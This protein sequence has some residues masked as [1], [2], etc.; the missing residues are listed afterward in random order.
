MPNNSVSAAMFTA[1]TATKGVIV[2]LES[3]SKRSVLKEKYADYA[4]EAVS[5]VF[6]RC[7]FWWLNPLLGKGFK[8]TLSLD[9]LPSIDPEL[10]SNFQLISTARY[11]HM[12]YRVITL[13]RGN[14]IPLVY[15]KTLSL[16]MDAVADSAAVTMMSTDVE[17]ISSGLIYIHDT[18]GSIIEIILCLSLLW[19]EL[20]VATITPIVITSICTLVA[21][22]IAGAAAPRQKAWIEAIQIRVAATA[23]MLGSIKGVKMSG[24]TSRLLSNILGL[25]TAEINAS[26]K[27]RELLII[28]LGLA[29]TGNAMSPPIAFGIFV[30][31]D[32]HRGSGTLDTVTAFTALTLFALLSSPLSTLVESGTNTMAAIG[33]IER[34]R[35]YLVIEN[36]EE[37]RRPPPLNMADPETEEGGIAM[38]SLPSQDTISQRPNNRKAMVCV[39]GGSS[40]WA[41]GQDTVICDL[42]FQIYDSDLVMI[43][44]PVG[45]GKSTLLHTM[46]GEITYFDGSLETSFSRAAFCGQTPW[47]TNGTVQENIL[48]ISKFDKPWYDTVVRACAL[49]QDLYHFPLGDQTQV[50][51]NGMT[52]SGGQKQRL[53]LARAL[54]SRAN[55]VIVD[56]I[57]SGLDA[58]TGE[59]VFSEVFGPNGLFRRA[60]TTVIFATNLVDQLVYADHIIALGNDGRLV[61]QGTFEELNTTNGYVQSLTITRREP[62]TPKEST[63]SFSKP[64]SSMRAMSTLSN[65]DD[66]RRVGDI[67]VYKYYASIIGWKVLTAFM[68]L[69]VWPVFC[70]SFPSEWVM[71]WAQSNE[72]HPNQHI[73]LYLGVYLAFGVLAILGIVCLCWFLMVNLVPRTSG[74]LHEII[75]KTTLSAPMSFFANT[76]TGITLNRFSQ[77]LQ[78]VDM[79]LPIALLNTALAGMLCSAQMIF[80]SVSARYIAAVIP[81]CITIFYA[82]QKFYLRTSRQLRLLD[83]EARSPLFSHF[84]ETLNGLA[85]IR[86]LCW[87][88]NLK[89]RNRE[90][91]N[92]SQKPFYLLYCV[93]RWLNIVLD[94]TF[95]GLAVLLVTIVVATQGKLS[96]GFVG[97]AL[98]NVVNFNTSIKD[99]ITYWTS[100]ETSIGAV[101]RIR[102][103]ATVTESEN[104][105]TEKTNPP[106]DWPTEGSIL[107]QD[108]SASYSTGTDPVLQTVTLSI[109]AGEKIAVCGRSGSG[110]S[111]LVST[112]FRLLDIESGSITI[113]GIDISTLPRDAIRSRLIAIPQDPY[114]LYGTVRLNVDPFQTASEEDV[115]G[116]LRKVGLWTMVNEKGGLDIMI[117]EGTFSHGQRQLMSLARSLLRKGKILVLDEATSSVDKKT[118]EV[119]Q[120]IIREDFKE[121]TIIAIAH[122]LKTILDFDKVAVIDKGRLLEYEN[123]TVLLSQQSAFRDLYRSLTDEDDDQ[124]KIL[125]KNLN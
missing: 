43:I 108:I 92:Q 1:A 120:Q 80:V 19:L 51:S 84:L 85:V 114:L 18:W 79:E 8:K 117:D 35:K 47:I 6:D 24:L 44:G 9:D 41:R 71:L 111:S 61:Q 87:E 57:L 22:K 104:L 55:V 73:A 21:L 113:D 10:L 52:L 118:E 28:V 34:I 56:D 106:S 64:H 45:S 48:G 96:G 36:R 67:Q 83:I 72:S 58:T 98:V 123:P 97:V 76:D 16:S 124:Y 3:I 82:I 39:H 49:E 115:I 62:K 109:K 65:D 122:R 69:A 53:A 23:A 88:D 5:N 25:R 121:Y 42:D 81:L 100:L 125:Q 101:S 94:L 30:L 29:Y 33:C 13:L 60:K 15:N 112:I 66:A 2:V 90:L 105:P 50:G 99:L 54:Y 32:R 74:T 31:I 38:T 26:R 93:Q 12:T 14:L 78:L 20:G 40:W 7:L 110:K 46:L 37:H 95:A 11:Q 91:L 77:D 17:R 116:A 75:L 89:H 68:V 59:H 63:A 70:L 86:A 103:F 119:M 27:F 102:T 4:M 107:I